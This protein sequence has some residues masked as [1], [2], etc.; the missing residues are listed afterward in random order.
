MKKNFIYVIMAALLLLPLT[1]NAADTVMGLACEQTSVYSN[2]DVTCYLTIAPGAPIGGVDTTLEIPAELSLVKLE[3]V[4]EGWQ[5]TFDA[6]DPRIAIYS[7]SFL[8]ESKNLVKISLKAG[9][10][11]EKK[12]VE[13]KTST[14]ELSD[15]TFETVTAAGAS[16]SIN[17]LAGERPT[18][19]P[20]VD[21]TGGIGTPDSTNNT[22]GKESPE[23]G[24]SVLTVVGGAAVLLAGAFVI[25]MTTKKSRFN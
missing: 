2:E 18:E 15:E 5:G 1:V 20:P 21:A 24:A 22:T 25:S 4:A 23:T 9:T 13:L 16:T 3:V 11:S 10:I 12:T 7:D 8:S 19:T 14:V 17:L 6:G